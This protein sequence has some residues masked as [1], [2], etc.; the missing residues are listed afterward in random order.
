MQELK[1]G[2]VRKDVMS[3]LGL[4]PFFHSTY[5]RVVAED[6]FLTVKSSDSQGE[7][8]QLTDGVIIPQVQYVSLLTVA[9]R[10]L[11]IAKTVGL[12]SS[13]AVSSSPVLT[14]SLDN[15]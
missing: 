10:S 7:D 12:S 9:L 3:L 11:H 8:W 14:S 4:F 15:P 5:V 13:V 2:T 1:N 6:L